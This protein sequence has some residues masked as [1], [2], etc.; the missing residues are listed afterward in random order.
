MQSH[1]TKSGVH[2]F[3]LGTGNGYSVLDMIKAFEAASAWKF[4]IELKTVALVILL[5]VTLTLPTP[6]RKPVGNQAWFSADDGRLM[7]LGQQQPKW[8]RWLSWP[9]TGRLKEMFSDGLFIWKTHILSAYNPFI[10]FLTILWNFMKKIL[11]TGGAGFIGSA[12]VR[13]LSKTP[14]TLSSM[15]ISW[16]M[17]A[18]WNLWPR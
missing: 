14:K 16:L 11:V 8:L 3:N 12:V 4:L 18:I 9:D 13:L 7:A 5:F 2:I 6:K 10:L 1:S 17:P 15:S